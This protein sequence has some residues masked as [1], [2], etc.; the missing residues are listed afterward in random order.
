M[1]KLSSPF[2][3]M[4]LLALL[5]CIAKAQTPQQAL[6]FERQGNFGEAAVVWTE[7]TQ[8]NPQDAGAF[9]HLGF[10]LAKEQKY[11]EAASTYRKALALNPNLP[12]LQLNLGL[13]EFK[14][15][16]Y[17]AA[18]PAPRRALCSE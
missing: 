18:A 11:S 9:A 15:G 3:F 16:N 2:A 17:R 14:Q 10:V 7:V 13:A 12:G 8:R 5:P 4:A 1:K 6:A